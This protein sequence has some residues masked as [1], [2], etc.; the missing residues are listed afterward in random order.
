MHHQWRQLLGRNTNFIRIFCPMN[1]TNILQVKSLKSARC[2]L[3]I[4]NYRINLAE[5]DSDHVQVHYPR[6]QTLG[7]YKT[8]ISIDVHTAKIGLWR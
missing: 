5:I 3:K 7:S 4:Q 1:L 6:L 2:L 8:I